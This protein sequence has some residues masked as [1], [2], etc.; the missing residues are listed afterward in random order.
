MSFYLGL[1][2]VALMGILTQTYFVQRK[3]YKDN[4]KALTAKASCTFIPVLLCLYALIHTNAPATKWFLFAGVFICM[5]ADVILGIQ[6]VAGMLTFLIA[7]LC[8]IAYFFTLAPF[9]GISLIIFIVLY[10]CVARLFWR[11]VPTLGSRLI[12]FAVYPAVLTLMI[13]IAVMLPFALNSAGAICIAVGAG[14]F[15]ISDS[16]LA[17][18]TLGTVTQ[19]KDRMVMYLYYPAVYLLA[20]SAFFM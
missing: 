11:Y 7:H 3:N 5:I 10:A 13:S 17:D 1:I 6:F 14:L 15:G 9:N 19:V 2:S 4:A 18:T 16:V 20:V 8:F 12:P